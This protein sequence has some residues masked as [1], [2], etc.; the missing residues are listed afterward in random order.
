M[1]I[2]KGGPFDGTRVTGNAISKLWIVRYTLNGR[3]WEPPY[4]MFYTNFPPGV[5]RHGYRK[6]KDGN[7]HHAWDRNQ[8]E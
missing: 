3:P 8:N 2:L 7:F 4:G 5:M 1:T 6:Q